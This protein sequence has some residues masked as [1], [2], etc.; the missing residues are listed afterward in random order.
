MVKFREA[1]LSSGR[2]IFLG[3]D[4]ASN[5]ELVWDAK[6]TDVLLHTEMPGSPFVN[7]GEGPSKDEIYESAVFCAK[8]SQVWRDVKR[9]VV[10]N[11]MRRCDMK[12]DKRMKEGS[13]SVLR[14]EKVKVKKGDVLRLERKLEN[15]AD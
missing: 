13:W 9:D 10:V 7:L 12:K 11:G 3:R 6:P 1:E 2:R 15:E 14:Q 4:S 5:D 8:F